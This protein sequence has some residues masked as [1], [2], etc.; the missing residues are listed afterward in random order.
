[1]KN[2]PGGKQGAR[3]SRVSMLLPEAE[4]GSNPHDPS[5]A[6]SFLSLPGDYMTKIINFAGT[7][8]SSVF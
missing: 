5:L 6:T 3:I 4:D 7:N 1:M 8:R 2:K